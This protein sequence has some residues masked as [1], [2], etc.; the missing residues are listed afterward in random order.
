[1]AHPLNVI[2]LGT[3]PPR[4]CGIATFTRDLAHACNGIVQGP[5]R[6]VALNAAGDSYD[7]PP[8]V[9]C[10]IR[11][12]HIDDYHRAAEW[13][14][15]SAAD[16]LCVQHEFG[17]FGGP[18]GAHLFELLRKVDKPVVTT[19][20]TVLRDPEP[21]YEAATRR[22]VER[23][24][25]LVVLS[26]AAR[27]ILVSRYGAPEEKIALIY[28]G[29]PD[30]PREGAWEA[31]RRLGF[32]GRFV[33]L[34]FGLLSRNK[35]IETAIEALPPVVEQRP[36]LL[37]VVLGV[38]HPEVKKYE[39]ERYREALKERVRELSLDAHVRFVDE[40][41]DLERL[42]DYIAASDVYITPYLGRE[43]VSSGTLS[44][45]LA[46]GKAVI[47]TPYW[48]AEELLADGRGVLVPFRD[49]GALSEAILSLI[50][51]P[52]RMEAVRT[53]AYTFGRKMIWPEVG[54]A[55]AALFDRV[56]RAAAAV[57]NG[58]SAVRNGSAPCGGR[59]GESPHFHLP[60]VKLDHL[61]A[62]TDDTGLIQ[63]AAWG[64]PDRNFGYS[65][66]DVGRALVALLELETEA[67]ENRTAGA[68][69]RARDELSPLITRYMSFLQYAQTE[70]GHFHN[71]MSY[72]RRF[73][74]EHGS[75]DTLGRAMWG[76]GA[77][78]QHRS[79]E[80]VGVLAE[81]ML[82]RALQPARATTSP[83][84][85]AYMICGLAAALRRGGPPRD[86]AARD[87][88]RRL[89]PELADRLC[90]LY[91]KYA[92][93]GW[94]WF[95]ER[96]TYGNAKM[97]EALLLA[98]TLTGEPRYRRVGLSTLDF[99]LDLCWN[100]SYFEL[101][102]NEGW[103][104]RGG[105]P[106]LFG[107]QPI[108]AGY[109]VEACDTAY[110]VTGDARYLR[111]AKAAFAW[112]LG[113]NRLGVPLYDERTGAVADGIDAQGVSLNQGAESIVCYLLALGRVRR[114]FAGELPEGSRGGGRAR[115]GRS[116]GGAGS[117]GAAGSQDAWAERTA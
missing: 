42:L 6:I 22:L 23:S 26:R 82:K 57:G 39:G 79:R 59:R 65:T 47:S 2:Y 17:I 107:Q 14:D 55:Y 31:K 97:S 46:A 44:Y 88:Y 84:A 3:Y 115:P 75:D 67:A 40:Y 63:H 87:A 18:A 109:L 9:E 21:E 71:F 36:D 25:A 116:A 90:A 101:I 60:E 16:V 62:L 51:D 68:P 54:K 99:L 50:R 81:Q 94:R 76:L 74:D 66:D 100:G 7:Y 91:G 72:D 86:S 32:E 29:V 28:H 34:T 41:V 24:D 19:L 8:E 80:G 1:M 108:D 92:G 106:A 111:F 117:G 61:K 35:G 78:V 10:E 83:R 53:A 52:E 98:H 110:E 104:E 113:Q 70:E 20:H 103:M 58:A 5:P 96:I 37:Y 33:L 112:F 12:D 43:Q 30:I 73:L 13:I 38:T 93:P 95:E 56:R 4:R 105:S 77:V 15:R 114:R 45:A 89:L 27:E 64:V 48:Y 11:R 69:G 102:G 49:S 85:W